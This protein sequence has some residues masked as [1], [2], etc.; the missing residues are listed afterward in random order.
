M[1]VQSERDEGGVPMLTV[2]VPLAQLSRTPSVSPSVTTRAIG[3]FT[4][5]AVQADQGMI[6]DKDVRN[7]LSVRVAKMCISCTCIYTRDFRLQYERVPV[8]YRC[9]MPIWS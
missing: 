2:K 8:W 6:V 4:D 5:K 7:C 9:W 1:E 3:M